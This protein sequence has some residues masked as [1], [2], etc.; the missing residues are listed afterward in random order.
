MTEAYPLQWPP[1]WKQTEHPKRSAFGEYTFYRMT[2]EVKDELRRLGAKDII[3]STNVPLRLDGQPYSNRK[4]EGSHGVA[5]Y[6]KLE[7]KEQ[8][9][10]CDK[11]DKVED[12]LRAI[13]KTIEALR[14]LERW[15]AKEMVDAAFR[16]FQALPHY[17][18]N[19]IIGQQVEQYFHHC[20]SLDEV[21]MTFKHKRKYMHPDAGGSNSDFA[22]LTSQYSQAK[23]RF[24][25]E[26]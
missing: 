19:V 25:D 5:V 13:F 8:C 22:E 1:G 15:G 10:P 14:G 18:D 21:E 3:I 16:G 23:K 26:D 6:F 9:I 7:G 24:E 4:P 11:W 2:N 20:K 17:E 12:N